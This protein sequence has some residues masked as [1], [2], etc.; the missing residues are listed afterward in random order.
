MDWIKIKNIRWEKVQNIL[1]VIAILSLL[2]IGI[3]ILLTEKSRNRTSR[4]NFNNRNTYSF[5]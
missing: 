5:C 3:E 2:G 4:G 1:F